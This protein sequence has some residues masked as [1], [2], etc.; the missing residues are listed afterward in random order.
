MNVVADESVDFGIIN[1]LRNK[2]VSVFSIAESN[3]SV[4]DVKVLDISFERG[5]LLLTEDKDFGE[6]V[7]RLRL[8]HRGILLIRLHDLP[9][10]ERV[11]I[12]T[13][14]ILKHFPELLNNFCVLT[15]QGLRIKNIF[16]T[17]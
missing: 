10:S 17:N 13:E 5:H 2:G 15:K 8:K 4:N 12:A 1:N 6:L 14:T 11:V 7:H 16:S 3:P 9:R